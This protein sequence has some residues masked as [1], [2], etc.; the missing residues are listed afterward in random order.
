MTTPGHRWRLTEDGVA[1]AAAIGRWLISEFGGGFQ[2][3]YVSPYVRARETAGL[4]GLPGARWR[5]NRA[6]RERD[7]GDISSLPRAEFNSRPE[8]RQSVLTRKNDPLYW[9]APNGESIAQVSED[10]VRNFL[11]TLGRKAGGFQVVAVTHGN[12]MEAARLVLERWTDEE[13]LLHY[14][15]KS[16]DI[17]N[18]QALQ[19]SRVDPDTGALASRLTWLRKAWPVGRDGA[20][21]IKQT[22]WHHVGVRS[23]SNE[24]LL[25]GVAAVPKVIPV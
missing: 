20:W 24:K 25:E 4:L 1:Q 13:F 15:D 12:W 19:Y 6:L 10:R 21:T 7:Y 16:E 18:C 3:Y 8:W 5:I 17:Q 23:L 2:R 22:P 11:S 9:V 14:R